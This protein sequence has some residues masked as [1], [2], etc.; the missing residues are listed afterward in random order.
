MIDDSVEGQAARA[1]VTLLRERIEKSVNNYCTRSDARAPSLTFD[2][3]RTSF[4][5]PAMQVG[6]EHLRTLVTTFIS[7]ILE[8]DHRRTLIDIRPELGTAEPFFI[9]LFK[10]CLLF[11][12]LLKN[13]ASNKGK[14]LEAVLR[15]LRAR[16]GFSGREQM[17][18]SARDFQKIINDLPSNDNSVYWAI[19]QTG[20]IRNTT[21][22]NLGWRVALDPTTYNT[23]AES[24]AIACLHTLA[25]LYR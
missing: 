11:E 1:L 17:V 13:K 25:C 23:L 7:F 12:S 14:K 21:G 20:R 4:L 2:E 16:L 15:E 24:V 5:L 8:L 19:V 22:H 9:H 3:I 6:N 10:G 18:I